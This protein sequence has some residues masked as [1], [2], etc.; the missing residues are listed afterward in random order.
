[1]VAAVPH[2]CR[3]QRP[4]GTAVFTT[5]PSGQVSCWSPSIPTE[6]VPLCL[7]ADPSPHSL[8]RREVQGALGGAVGEIHRLDRATEAQRGD[9]GG[10]GGGLKRKLTWHSKEQ[11]CPREGENSQWQRCA[12]LWG[13][14][15][16][17]QSGA[18]K[19]PCGWGWL[20]GDGHGGTLTDCSMLAFCKAKSEKIGVVREER[21]HGGGRLGGGT[22]GAHN[23]VD[24]GVD[25]L[26]HVEVPS[27]LQAGGGEVAAVGM[28]CGDDVE[29]L[30]LGVG[31]QSKTCGHSCR[32]CP[33]DML[34]TGVPWPPWGPASALQPAVCPRAH[35]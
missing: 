15:E 5:L 3:E 29:P 30:V 34:G 20:H 6:P 10:R 12:G 11:H 14:P 23:H 25:G 22:G 31:G 17:E 2:G 19:P 32:M 24:D 21:A 18:T 4:H 13:S 7:G 35:P 28:V 33:G 9:T 26:L 8:D 27:R 1:M 16:A